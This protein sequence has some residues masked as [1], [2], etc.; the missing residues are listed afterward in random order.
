MHNV[1]DI[2]LSVLG[3]YCGFSGSQY[4]KTPERAHYYKL[5]DSA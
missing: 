4:H 1:T 5:R 2:R 3:I